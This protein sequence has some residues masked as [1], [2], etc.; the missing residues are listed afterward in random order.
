MEEFELFVKL[1]IETQTTEAVKKLTD[2]VSEEFCI[3]DVTYRSVA[4]GSY[5]FRIKVVDTQ[6]SKIF[7]D[8]EREKENLGIAVFRVYFLNL[9]QI[10]QNTIDL[11][12]EMDSAI[13]ETSTEVIKPLGYSYK[14]VLMFTVYSFLFFMSSWL[15]TRLIFETNRQLS[16]ILLIVSLI[17]LVPLLFGIIILI[18]FGLWADTF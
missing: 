10:F 18:L 9:E 5:Y 3:P 2:F 15:L 11:A 8:L 1:K 7:L 13:G 12:S 16:Y 17:S 4:A 6:M 14:T